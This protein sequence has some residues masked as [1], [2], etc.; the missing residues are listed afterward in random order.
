MSSTEKD[1]LFSLVQSLS[2]F[3]ERYF[4]KFT[5]LSQ[6]KPEKLIE[7]FNSIRSNPDTKVLKDQF[8]GLPV[9]KLKLR[10][11]I[12]ASLR[13]M[14]DGERI[15]SKVFGHLQDC[16]ILYDRG[17]YSDSWKSLKEARNLADKYEL[18]GYALEISRI[19]KHRIQE[20]EKQ[21]ISGVIEVHRSKDT[22]R[23]VKINRDS[24]ISGIYHS[25]FAL[26]RESG[27]IDGEQKD[28]IDILLSVGINDS[29]MS[30]FYAKQ[31][32]GINCRA[33]GKMADA[34][35]YLLE[36]IDLWD[37]HPHRKREFQGQYKVLLFNLAMY[38]I[39]LGDYDAAADI[40]VRA[41]E[42]PDL[43]LNNKAETFQNLAS[44]D[45]LLIL[46]K[47][48]YHRKE[49]IEKFIKK[50]IQDY[51][52]KI[53]AARQFSI[54]YNLMILSMIVE[55][56]KGAWFWLEEIISQKKFNV[57]K[58]VHYSS[59]LLQLIMFYELEYWDPPDSVLIRTYRYL[60]RKDQ[61]TVFK[62]SVLQY[63][64][65]L[66]QAP[67][68]EKQAIL[69]EMKKELTVIFKSEDTQNDRLGLQVVLGWVSGKIENKRITEILPLQ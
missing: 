47:G 40:R 52:D 45:L 31:A 18:W 12:L 8:K 25:F 63:I 69:I 5:D 11:L 37:Q 1:K 50:G 21:D 68:L 17:L 46:N 39:S 24:E 6:K 32:L 60:S 53:N 22:N 48:E 3:E 59:R 9:L 20:T 4:F 35:Q 34:R 57:R 41:A 44:L 14:Q 27:A 58:E 26:Y 43:T 49:E 55:D 56:F 29:F 66:S 38:N 13:T 36:T 54:C 2:P 65:K 19:E 61:L 15:E 7:L 23:N 42:I 16:Q 30:Q 62:R 67:E 28:K 64:S 51:T 10:N 33:K